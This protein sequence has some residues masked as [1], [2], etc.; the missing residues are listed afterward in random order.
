MSAFI[1]VIQR[2]KLSLRKYSRAKLTES[3][4]LNALSIMWT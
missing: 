2:V 1:T 4:Y 3:L